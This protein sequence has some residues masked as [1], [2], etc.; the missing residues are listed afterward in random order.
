MASEV[1]GKLSSRPGQPPWTFQPKV[2]RQR[3]ITSGQQTL[4]KCPW[5]FFGFLPSLQLYIHCWIVGC[6]LQWYAKL[7]KVRACTI[8]IQYCLLNKRGGACEP[9]PQ[10]LVSQEESRPLASSG[11]PQGLGL[12]LP[13]L[14]LS[15]GREFLWASSQPFPVGW[16]SPLSPCR[17]GVHALSHLLHL[18]PHPEACLYT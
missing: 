2:P 10:H 16:A 18:A 8:K 13:L 6:L 1:D 14:V 12:G 17:P 3:K 7:P 5:S 9:H 4:T 11:F 15:T